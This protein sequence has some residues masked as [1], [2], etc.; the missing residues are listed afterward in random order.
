MLLCIDIG[1]TNITIGAYEEDHLVFVSRLATDRAYTKDQYA[2]TLVQLFALHQMENRRYTGAAIS[3][4]VPELTDI[5]AQ[6]VAQVIGHIPLTLGPGIKTGLNIVTDNPAQVG[7][8][9]VAG[10]VA[11]K[12]LYELPC[13][14]IDLGTATKIS[15]LDQKGSFLGVAISPGVAISLESLSGRTSQ[16][17]RISLGKPTSAIGKNT[18]ESMQSG[19]V[20]GTASMIDG[21]CEKMSEEMDVPVKTVV[22]TGGFSSE[23]I[24]SCQQRIIHNPDLILYGLKTIYERNHKDFH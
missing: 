11:A 16:L 21:L 2:I 22:A 8:D 20:Y 4:V 13:L 18:I 10:A 1:N 19:V 23:I 17:P 6:A 24:K 3:S 15:A 9:L 14:V 12:H 7:A 5:I